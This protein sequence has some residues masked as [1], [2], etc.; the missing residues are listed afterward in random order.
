LLS[1]SFIQKND[2]AIIKKLTENK[3][4]D[5]AICSIAKAEL[6]YGARKSQFV[7]KNLGLL[8]HFFDQFKS[9][10]FDDSCTDFYGTQ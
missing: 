5:F 9:L 10:P 4:D 1:Q 3:P 6:L 2:L 8:S 7:D